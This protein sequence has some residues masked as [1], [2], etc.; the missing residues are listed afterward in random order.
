MY[1]YHGSVA[2]LVSLMIPPPVAKCVQTTATASALSCVHDITTALDAH[3]QKGMVGNSCQMRAC[4]S[5][6]V[7]DALVSVWYH[8]R[9]KKR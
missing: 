9:E 3:V 5:R 6:R 8:D 7:K 4:H 2:C 1:A